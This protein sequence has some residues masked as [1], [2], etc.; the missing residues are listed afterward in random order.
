MVYK[1]NRACFLI[2]K[3]MQHMFSVF[4]SE[5]IS[6]QYVFFKRATVQTEEEAVKDSQSVNTFMK[7]KGVSGKTQKADC[8]PQVAAEHSSGSLCMKPK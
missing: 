5:A 6:F 8:V 7:K 3:Y 1:K 4:P 2:G